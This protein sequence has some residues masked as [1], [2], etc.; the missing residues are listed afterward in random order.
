M[1]RLLIRGGRL[2]DPV[3]GIDAL[4]DI[5]I[6]GETIR[7]VEPA[8][9]PG[10]DTAVLE[11][12]GRVVLPGLVDS[13]VH[14]ASRPEG[15]AMLARA[16]VTAALDMNGD[17]VAMAAGLQAAS[18][19]LTVGFLYPVAPGNTVSGHDPDA[20][21]LN[22]VAREAREAGA[23]G[24]KVLGGHYPLTPRATRRVLEIAA[25]LGLYAAVHAGTSESGSNIRGLEEL[26]GLAAGLP[27]HIAHI[28]SYCRGQTGRDPVEEALAALKLL[29]GA[30]N[31]R[32][33]SYLG[34]IN[35]TNGELVNGAPKSNVTKTCL[36]R[37]GYS[38]DQAGMEAAIRD[39][40]ARVHGRRDDDC[41][42][43][44][45]EEGLAAF[46]AAG[47]RIHLSF[48]V[49]S[50]AAAIVLATAKH[51]DGR[52]VVDAISTDGG[53]IPRNT[54]LQ[55]GL[56]LVR[57][58]ALSLGELVLK[59]SR[60]PALMLGLPRKGQLGPG[61]DAD[62]VILDEAGSAPETVLARGTPVFRGGRVLRQKACALFPG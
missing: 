27:V 32:S 38:L 23:F 19:G 34:L 51:A 40:W 62:L 43:L 1:N 30:A 17:P 33:E 14:I 7:A 46:R 24:L 52:F 37:R 36:A 2:A 59:A 48:Q 6:E 42:L 41:V 26:I 4:R 45:P 11:A 50:P 16:G 9:T 12:A 58:G 53:G 47:S 20:A 8:L 21:E 44:P 22:R 18:T 49:N 29:R 54:T 31:V 25:E 15:Y 56:A 60:N 55:Q 13:H 28:N 10:D 3:N 35:G 57:Y 5:L 39:G 61:A